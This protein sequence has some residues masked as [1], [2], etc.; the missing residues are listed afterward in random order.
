MHQPPSLTGRKITRR[1]ESDFFI[2]SVTTCKLSLRN[3]FQKMEF[4]FLMGKSLLNFVMLMMVIS[5]KLILNHL[6]YLVVLF[7]Q[8]LEL[9]EQHQEYLHF[10]YSVYY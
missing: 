4:L 5:L 8:V 3:S 6:F 10:Y 2:A 9:M 7:L 1:E